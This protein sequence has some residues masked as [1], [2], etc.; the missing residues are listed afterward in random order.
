MEET[1]ADPVGT[2]TLHEELDKAPVWFNKQDV[3]RGGR[4][5]VELR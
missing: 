1:E 4:Y 3:K 5:V 2:W